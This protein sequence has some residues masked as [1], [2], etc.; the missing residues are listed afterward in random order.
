MWESYHPPSWALPRRAS[1]IS[2]THSSFRYN[3]AFFWAV[4]TSTGVG[5]DVMPRTAAEV[6]F[7]TVIICYGMLMYASVIGAVSAAVAVLDA[8]GIKRQQKLS[9]VKSY[10]LQQNVDR[11]LQ[12]EIMAYYGYVLSLNNRD[13]SALGDLPVM[14]RIKLELSLKQDTVDAVPLFRNLEAACILSIV[15]HLKNAVALPSEILYSAGAFGDRMFI[16]ERGHVVLSVPQNMNQ[17][18]ALRKGQRRRKSLATTQDKRKMSMVAPAGRRASVMG[19]G[20]DLAHWRRTMAE[21]RAAWF[22]GLPS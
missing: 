5:M 8:T 7:T 16:V 12:Q 14:L 6:A 10:M 21:R 18:L 1:R 20:D 19:N 13:S 4:Q 9:A 22:C 15:H 3:Q 2:Y 11:E 17:F